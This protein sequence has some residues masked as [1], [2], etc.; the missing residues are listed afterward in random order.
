MQGVELQL[1]CSSPPSEKTDKTAKAVVSTWSFEVSEASSGVFIGTSSGG[2]GS[3]PEGLRGSRKPRI[4]P[5]VPLLLSV[6]VGLPVQLLHAA[7][8]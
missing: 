7:G 6:A 8:V 2:E 4:D 1:S 3:Y 5:I